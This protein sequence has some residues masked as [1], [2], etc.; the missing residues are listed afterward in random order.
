MNYLDSI[1][2]AATTI[3]SAALKPN[4][5]GAEEEARRLRQTLDRQAA[6]QQTKSNGTTK[7]LLIGAGVLVLALVGFVALRRK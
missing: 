4:D 7:W 5:N 3:G 6:Q 1:L 2:N